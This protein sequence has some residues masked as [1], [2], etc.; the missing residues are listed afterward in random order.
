MRS[1]C[2]LALGLCIAMTAGLAQAKSPTALTDLTDA[3]QQAK[4]EGK[5]LFIQYGRPTCGNCQALRGYIAAHS[6][7][8]PAEK[9]VYADLN[10]D[11][12]KTAAAFSE[13]FKGE[14][15]TLPFV[16][17]ADAEGK[18]LA[19]R[20]GYGEPDEFQRMIKDALKSAPKTTG[21]RHP[22]SPGSPPGGSTN[23]AAAATAPA[24]PREVRTWKTKSGMAVKAAFLEQ[25]G[26][27]VMLK[28]EDGS[29]VRLTAGNLSKEDQ[30][31]LLSIKEKGTSSEKGD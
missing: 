29:K 30:E 19:F 11:E 27:F 1:M 26:G 22:A 21:V 23:A 15:S 18:Q 31:Y 2:R 4:A 13:R 17:I 9:F 3:L 7:K 25:S 28:K 12:K 16:V 5:L 20:S 10:C 14:G 8:L 24:A 6:L